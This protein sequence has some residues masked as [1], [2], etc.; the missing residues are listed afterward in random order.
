MGEFR[1]LIDITT[2]TSHL[3]LN[4]LH[5]LRRQSFDFSAHDPYIWSLGGF[6]GY[7][8]N[9]P[10]FGYPKSYACGDFNL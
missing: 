8:L 5:Q 2:N 10:D 1:H 7:P 9:K 4:I 6:R 3:T